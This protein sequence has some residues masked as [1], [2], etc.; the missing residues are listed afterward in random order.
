MHLDTIAVHSGH[1]PDPAT[2]AFMPPLHL[3]T[4]FVREPDLSDRAGFVYSRSGMR[5]I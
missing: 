2:G 5:T 4:T 3:S 1:E